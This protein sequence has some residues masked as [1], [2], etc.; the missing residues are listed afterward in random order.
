MQRLFY[1]LREVVWT[2]VAA[3]VLTVAAIVVALIYPFSFAL[4]CGLG[5]GAVTMAILAQRA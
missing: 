1:A 2:S 3:I 4:T 5:L